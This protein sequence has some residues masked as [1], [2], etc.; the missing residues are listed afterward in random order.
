M[1]T[2]RRIISIILSVLMLVCMGTSMIYAADTP[3]T[4]TINNETSGHTY[5]AYQIFKGDIADGKLTNISWGS[6]VN[7]AALLE[8]LNELPAYANCASAEDVADV[9]KDFDNNSEEIDAFAAVVGDNLAAAAATS[10]A[11]TEVV[12]DDDVTYKYE[13]NVTGDG[14]YFVKDKD[15]SDLSGDAFTKYILKVVED[16]TVAA[17]DDV[18]EIDKSIQVSNG[19]DSEKVKITNGSV[20]DVVN[21]VIDSKVP[22]MDGYKTY[23]FEVSDTMSKGLTFNNDISVMIGNTVLSP[24][25]FTVNTEDTDT[26]FKLY[27]KEFIKYKEQA[28]Q[29]IV[30]TYSAT[31][32]QDAVVGSGANENTA[33]LNYS[34]NPNQSNPD[35][36]NPNEPNPSN[37]SGTTPESKTK[38]YTTG[39]ELLKVDAGNNNTTL[40]GAKFVIS[41]TSQKVVLVNKEIYQQS[42]D[43]IY[44][45]LKDGTYTTTNPS[46]EDINADAYE[47]TEIKYEKVKVIDKTNSSEDFEAEGWVNENGILTFDGLGEGDYEIEELVAPD[48]YNLL[49]DIINVKITF[50]NGEWTASSNGKAL[51]VEDGIV[52][53]T[54]ENKTGAELPSTG[55]TGTTVFYIVGGVLVAGAIVLLIAKKRMNSNK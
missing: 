37:P 1:K 38:T 48:G 53:L 49:T 36:D 2:T 8:T 22:N 25:D 6:G 11:P 35:P 20:G 47:S 19:E 55:G 28:G 26:T 39:I 50:N 41:G 32:N 23:L 52:K 30:I 21:Y 51:N 13:L 42:V 12:E 24:N 9:L 34:N 14:Y 33:Q 46:D 54:V 4:I 5:E 18:P 16:V 17:K 27:I 10:G 3:H 43:G 40:T 45:R 7:G 15:G 31:I 44:Y 29:A